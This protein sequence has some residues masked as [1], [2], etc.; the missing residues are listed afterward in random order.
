MARKERLIGTVAGTVAGLALGVGS[1]MLANVWWSRMTNELGDTLQKMNRSLEEKT[2]TLQTQHETDVGQMVRLR[3]ELQSLETEGY[4]QT[5]EENKKRGKRLIAAAANV[6]DGLSKIPPVKL[7][8]ELPEKDW[9][10][11]YRMAYNR[12]FFE[13]YT[14]GPMSWKIPDKDKIR[15]AVVDACGYTFLGF[16]EGD[17]FNALPE[18]I[19]D[20]IVEGL[21]SLSQC[22]NLTYTYNLNQ[23]GWWTRTA[24]FLFHVDGLSYV[25]DFK[26]NDERLTDD[27]FISEFDR[28]VDLM[29][30]V[31]QELRKFQRQQEAR[32]QDD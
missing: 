15:K 16:A 30:P 13:D 9:N 14:R 2:T 4:L 32:L 18:L 6:A 25:G 12:A 5:K 31:V 7:V 1:S 28:F 27:V 24:H 20:E 29:I 26:T 11:P 23:S 8:F 3:E 10:R 19:R 21:R 17:D 22:A